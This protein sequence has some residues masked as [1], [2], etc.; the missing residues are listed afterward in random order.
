MHLPAFSRWVGGFD[1][2]IAE[3]IAF[4]PVLIIA[5]ISVVLMLVV[6]FLRHHRL[7]S[8]ITIAGFVTAGLMTLQSFGAAPVHVTPLIILD[9]YSR[10]FIA[11]SCFTSVPAV[12]FA[13]DYLQRSDDFK[14]EYYILLS[15]AVLGAVV[16][17]ASAHFAAFFIGIELLSVSLFAMVGYLVNDDK[18][19]PA[20]LEA[21]VKYM[22]LSGV[23]SS[24][25]LF[26]V[27]LLYLNFG[28]LTFEGVH[29][30]V[31]IGALN[32]YGMLGTAMMII[33]LGF[34]L[35]W[36]PFHMW[37]PDVYEGAPVPVSAFLATISKVIVF[38][39]VL[40]LLVQSG[41]LDFENVVIV[42][43]FVGVLSMIAGNGLALM[44]NNLKRLLAY[45]SIA[46][47]GYLVVALIA[48]N[49][50]IESHK[51]LAM[52]A[53]IIYL[54]A[55]VLAT[56]IAFGTLSCLAHPE[57]GREAERLEDFR[58]LFF[59]RP[60]LATVFTIAL[61]SLAGI[62]LT[63]GFIAKF[64][65]FASGV[66]ES[67]WMLLFAVIVG[68]AVGLYYYLKVILEMCK[69]PIEENSASQAIIPLANKILLVA[70]AGL[71]I[72][73]GTFPAALQYHLTS[74]I[75]ALL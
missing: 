6:S 1:M 10:L 63:A 34:K 40:R 20:T 22:I 44:Q 36:V 61:F 43:G 31:A 72:F 39:I 58:G 18:K 24:F 38:A 7:V 55:Y 59:T 16:L 69:P 37:T 29:D 17:S 53:V 25:L 62:P 73:V 26:G 47:L 71:V 35:S 54:I 48:A 50:V 45:S 32:G 51:I 49:S 65:I 68:S 12:M 19:R 5:S 33:G 42:L 2:S 15:L 9:D 4:I 27:A 46:H 67:L 21:S 74:A 52:E 23:S 30:R 41:A 70:M 56:W 28:V 14:E 64:Y 75:R 66:S 3:L 57:S 11:L 60:W 8:L 13:Y